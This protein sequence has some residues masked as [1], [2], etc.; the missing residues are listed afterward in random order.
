MIRALDLLLERALELFLDVHLDVD[1]LGVGELAE[2]L[3]HDLALEQRD[4]GPSVSW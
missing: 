3:P 1:V 4:E 2:E